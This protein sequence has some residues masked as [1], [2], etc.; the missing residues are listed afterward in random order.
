MST[1]FEFYCYTRTCQQFWQFNTLYFYFDHCLHV[2]ISAFYHSV[3]PAF[4]LC[5]PQHRGKLK[6]FSKL[7]LWC[8]VY[9]FVIDW[10]PQHRLGEILVVYFLW[11]RAMSYRNIYSIIK[12][13]E[14]SIQRIPCLTRLA[15]T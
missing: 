7:M 8:L 5:T 13:L 3:W 10:I 12:L 4:E 15:P 9:L 6:Y 2:I 11:L 14:A 1:N